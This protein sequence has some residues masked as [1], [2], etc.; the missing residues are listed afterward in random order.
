[1]DIVETDMYMHD[2]MA[3]HCISGGMRRENK[4]R[5]IARLLYVVD[6]DI[7]N[8]FSTVYLAKLLLPCA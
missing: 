2:S 3:W 4:K 6:V 1:V 8:T 5:A 7:E